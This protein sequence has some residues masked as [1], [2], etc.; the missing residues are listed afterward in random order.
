MAAGAETVKEKAWGAPAGPSRTHR[1]SAG[2]TLRGKVA[3]A[4]GLISLISILHI[5]GLAQEKE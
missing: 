5:F 4:Q 2:K 1:A 3:G